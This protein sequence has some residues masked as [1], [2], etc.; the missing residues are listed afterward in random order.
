[1]PELA[2]ENDLWRYVRTV[3]RRQIL[4]ARA[5]HQAAKRGGEFRRTDLDLDEH[6]S[7]GLSHEQITEL[8]DGIEWCLDRLGDPVLRKV[9][10]GVWEGWTTE[11]TAASLGISSRTVERKRERLRATLKQLGLVE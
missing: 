10:N 11:E 9:M 2:D 1:M 4:L 6:P 7:P 5:H 8:R 3:M